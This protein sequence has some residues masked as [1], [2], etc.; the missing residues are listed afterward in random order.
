M[1]RRLTPLRARLLDQ[2]QLIATAESDLLNG[3]PT[4]SIN[5]ASRALRASA[6][7]PSSFDQF[8]IGV[9]APRITRYFRRKRAMQNLPLL[10]TDLKKYGTHK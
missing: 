7:K 5:L 9:M 6:K 10:I 2:Q 1:C 3:D 8:I 4:S